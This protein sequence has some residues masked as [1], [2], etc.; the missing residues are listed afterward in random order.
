MIKRIQK[1]IG[2]KLMKLAIVSGLMEGIIPDFRDTTT[3]GAVKNLFLYRFIV[4]NIK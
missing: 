3:V 2:Y 4:I 1:I